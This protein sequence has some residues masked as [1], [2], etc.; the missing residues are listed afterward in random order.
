[1]LVEVS[2]SEGIS[3]RHQAMARALVVSD[4]GTILPRPEDHTVA[5]GSNG[6]DGSNLVSVLLGNLV[7]DQMTAKTNHKVSEAPANTAVHTPAG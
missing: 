6:Q 3:S 7:H 5:G 2:S 1:M 4:P